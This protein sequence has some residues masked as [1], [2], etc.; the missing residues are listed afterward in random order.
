MLGPLQ[1]QSP[2]QGLA[3][4]MIPQDISQVDLRCSNE[5]GGFEILCL[6]DVLY[7]P[8]TGVNLIPQGQ[9]H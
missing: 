7:M 5:D 2:I 4:T 1:N 3:G 9:I 8:E 6:K